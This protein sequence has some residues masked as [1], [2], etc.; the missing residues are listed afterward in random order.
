[1][2]FETSV[3]GVSR[4]L[5]RATQASDIRRTDPWNLDVPD[6]HKKFDICGEVGGR[7]CLKDRHG[8]YHPIL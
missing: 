5:D 3:V 2:L 8:V 7:I 6:K 4:W 1:M